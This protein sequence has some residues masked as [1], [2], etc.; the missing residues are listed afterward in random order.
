MGVCEKNTEMLN[1]LSYKPSLLANCQT[2]K[3]QYVMNRDVVHIILAWSPHIVLQADAV[4]LS[5][6]SHEPTYAVARGFRTPWKLL[7]WAPTTQYQYQYHTLYNRWELRATVSVCV[8]VI[9]LC[10][11]K[12]S[13]MWT[14]WHCGFHEETA[15]KSF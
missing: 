2:F 14:F 3:G 1:F 11:P 8:C 7:M 6:R 13:E 12:E 9:F 4:A 15:Y 10:P 5:Q